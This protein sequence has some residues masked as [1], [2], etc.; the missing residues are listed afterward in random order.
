MNKWRI[1]PVLAAA[2]LM[3]A[4]GEETRTGKLELSGSAPVRIAD[5]GGQTVEFFSGPLKVEFGASG[6]R[7]FTVKLE[8]AGRTAKFSGKAPD[9]SDWNFTVRGRDIGQPTDFASRR[10]VELY[11]PVT[12]TTGHGM[13]CGF[14]GT[15]IT[16]EQW[17]KGNEDWTVAFTDAQG[18]Q[19]LGSFKSRREGD[20]YLIASR[21]L[22]CRERPDRDRG[23]RWDRLSASLTELQEKGVK[24]Q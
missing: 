11:G 2:V 1:I 8:Q 10:S 15:W 17:R 19:S 5:E 16:E 20:S 9:A 13:S 14:N 12:T 18:G 21:N 22:W 23:G 24:F 6:S 4:C 3:A 7:R